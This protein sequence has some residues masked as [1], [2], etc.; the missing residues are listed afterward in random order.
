[1]SVKR[2]F[3][4]EYGKYIFVKKNHIM[5][6]LSHVIMLISI[7]ISSFACTHQPITTGFDPSKLKQ[8]G[9]SLH[10]GSYYIY[11]IG[12]DIYKI[13][14]PGDP[15]AILGGLIGTDIYLIC[16]ESK[17]LMIDLGNNYIDGF[18]KDLIK[19]RENAK[20]EFLDVVNKLIGKPATGSCCLPYAPR[21]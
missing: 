9:D 1:M 4:K 18:E 17:A 10:Y 7:L 13:S 3:I 15:E 14:D 16:G 21:P 5:S 12:E 2:N 19:P 20:E 8:L 11:K 6:L